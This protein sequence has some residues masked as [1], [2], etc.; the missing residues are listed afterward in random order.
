MAPDKDYIDPLLN[1][2]LHD[3][4]V[5]PDEGMFDKIM[6]PDNSEHPVDAA[7]YKH[8][9][10]AGFDPEL[11]PRTT[12]SSAV[13]AGISSALA[14]LDMMPDDRWQAIAEQLP[15]EKNKRRYLFYASF[16]AL[17]AIGIW[18]S[19]V[20]LSTNE[21]LFSKSSLHQSYRNGIAEGIDEG[22][23]QKAYAYQQQL[24]QT[25]ASQLNT[26]S[27]NRNKRNKITSVESIHI[28]TDNIQALAKTDIPAFTSRS[29]SPSLSPEQEEHPELNLRRLIRQKSAAIPDANTKLPLPV[30]YGGKRLSP[31]FIAFTAGALNEH[32]VANKISNPNVHRDAASLFGKSTGKNSNGMQF[33]LQAGMHFGTRWYVKSGVSVSHTASE[34]RI[35]YTYRDIPI[36][37]SATTVILGYFNRSYNSST[38]VKQASKT[39][40][41][42]IAIPVTMGMK[43][44]ESRRFS[45]WT[46]A[47]FGFSAFR[48]MQADVFSFQ[49]EKVEA[50]EKSTM[51]TI[52]PAAGF[53]ARYYFKPNIQFL[54][55]VQMNYQQKRYYLENYHYTKQEISPLV[56]AGLLFHPMIKRK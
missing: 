29:T 10:H 1:R 38:V 42:N 36:Y 40:S 37:D 48:K 53:S 41:T 33:S 54:L 26:F 12:E 5:A 52:A 21:K 55:Q 30:R 13:D 19:S 47:G 51:M 49:D 28:N 50:P 56:S 45:I 39:S 43:L 7:L 16:A 11:Y 4:E 22:Y 32:T 23:E 20:L 8:L 24:S 31:F 25:M 2:L 6:P 44:F 3:I 18:G 35:D 34:S 9:A 15:P 46:E 17:I 14:D 27:E